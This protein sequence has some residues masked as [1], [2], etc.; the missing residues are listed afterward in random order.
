MKIKASNFRIYTEDG[1]ELTGINLETPDITQKTLPDNPG[2]KPV[3]TF[4]ICCKIDREAFK[5]LLEKIS[6]KVPTR[7]VNE[8]LKF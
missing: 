1:R 4:S 8:D 3:S 7:R 6:M 5:E 2:L